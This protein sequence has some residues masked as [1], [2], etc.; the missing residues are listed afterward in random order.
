MPGSVTRLWRGV[1]GSCVREIKIVSTQLLSALLVFAALIA[2]SVASAAPPN[3]YH[4]QSPSIELFVNEPWL[5]AIRDGKK[6][7]EGR[8]GP[9][10]EFSGWIGKQAR[11]YS[12]QQEVI[13]N[14]ID[15]HHYDTL[16][17]FLDA[18]G[19]KNAA[20]HLNSLEETV[21][22]YL[23][24]YPDDYISKHGG[25]NGIII[26]VVQPTSTR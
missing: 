9:L 19:W 24:F 2:P 8:A 21:N 18:E 7:V 14:V 13:V 26:S 4:H 10:E 25:M 17:E 15:V 23:Q 12:S 22:A 6:M 5:S 16:Q 1:P 3:N 20:P 11:F